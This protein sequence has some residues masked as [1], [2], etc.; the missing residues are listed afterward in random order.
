MAKANAADSKKSLTGLKKSGSKEK[1]SS[2][3]ALKRPEVL[4][5]KHSKV[6]LL[7]QSKQ[8]LSVKKGKGD[9][10]ALPKGVQDSVKNKE[11]IES[12]INSGVYENNVEALKKRYDIDGKPLTLKRAQALTEERNVF[13]AANRKKSGSSSSLPPKTSKANV[14]TKKSATAK[15]TA[16]PAAKKTATTAKKTTKK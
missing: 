14:A 11:R 2:G 6:N 7:A 8:M 4:P 13:F 16:K 10:S 9:I 1:M 3:K 12:I 15:S 5:E